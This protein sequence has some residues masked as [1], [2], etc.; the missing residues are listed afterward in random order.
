VPGKAWEPASLATRLKAS[1]TN[2][3]VTPRKGNSILTQNLAFKSAEIEELADVYF[4]RPAGM[5]V[6]TAARAIGLTPI[7]VTILGTVI[8]ISGGVLLYDERLGLIAFALLIAHSIF[9]SAD[10]QLARMTGRVT[11]LGR[12]LDGL[13]GYATHIAIYLAIAAG[14]LQRGAP[15]SVIV[16]MLLAGICSALHAGMYDYYRNTYIAVAVEGRVPSDTAGRMPGRF[17][18]LF[19]RYLAVQR[20]LLGLHG[21]VEEALTQN[22]VG[23]QIAEE[24]R[25]RYRECFY[26]RVRG[27]NLLGDNTRFYAVG[28]FACLHRLDLYFPFVLIPMNLAFLVL[29]FWQRQADQRFLAGP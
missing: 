3:L 12:A 14:L 11:A 13:S 1:T 26:S 21:K 18:R 5:V 7:G 17:G 29:W 8:G 23:G 9:D 15:R 6:A 27:W 25:R 4:F 20:Q 2:G 28:I 19:R 24:D 22:A 16:W 10:G